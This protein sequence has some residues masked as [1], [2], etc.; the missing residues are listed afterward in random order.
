MNYSAE[1][2]DFLQLLVSHNGSDLHLKVGNPPIIRV[3]KKLQPLADKKALT[4]EDIEQFVTLILTDTQMK[5]FDKKRQVDFSYTHMLGENTVRMRGYIFMDL[6]KPAIALRYIVDKVPSLEDLNLPPILS[7]VMNTQQGFFIITGPIGNGKTSALAAMIDEVNKNKAR[8][9]LTIEDPVEFIHK[10]KKSIITQREVGV[11]TDTFIEGLTGGLRADADII[12]IGEARD[13]NTIRTAIT[14]AEIGHLVLTTMHTNS[15]IQTIN[16]IIDSFP[17][18]EKDQI[19]QQLSQSLL[20]VLSI[21]LLPRLSGGLIPATE[22]LFNNDA[23]SNLI[24]EK[25]TAEIYTVLNTNRKEGMMSID[26]SLAELVRKQEV[27]L[28][29]AQT[30]AS[31]KGIFN[32]FLQ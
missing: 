25:R 2:D 28:E 5:T 16:R 19:I 17:S 23:V 32:K 30:Y 6:G 8:H 11:D 15:A 31:D 24:R 22:I 1:L 14:A 20:G 9:I 10:E 4:K 7:D 3:L 12:V 21:R 13:T 27:S 26:Q 29:I 18:A